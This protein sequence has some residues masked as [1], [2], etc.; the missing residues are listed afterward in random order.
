ML[1][2][3]KNSWIQGVIAKLETVLFELHLVI[4]CICFVYVLLFMFVPFP[5]IDITCLNTVG[6]FY[7]EILDEY[8]ISI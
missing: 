3:K 8:L 4:L 6:E 5:A 7:V 1:P 2:R